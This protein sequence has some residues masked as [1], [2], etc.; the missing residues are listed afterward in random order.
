MGG[1]R[2]KSNT[3][4]TPTPKKRDNNSIDDDEPTCKSLFDEMLK[5]IT[6]LENNVLILESS[7]AVSNQA[8]T[9]LSGEVDRLNSEVDRLEQY[10]RRSC[11]VISGIH[12]D[13]N[14]TTQD[15]YN[16]IKNLTTNH[17]QQESVSPNTFDF[18]FDKCHRIGPVKD[19][20]QSV[21]VKFR[22]DAFRE[23]LYKNRKCLPKGVK[24]RVSLTKKRIDILEKANEKIKELNG[25]KFAYAD[26]NGNLKLLLKEKTDK[27]RWTLQFDNLE[28]LD[29]LLDHPIDGPD[30]HQNQDVPSQT[31]EEKNDE[32]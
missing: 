28:E 32:F 17:L 27:G 12:P 20:K 22:S 31:T 2:K 4:S 25:V 1:S 3:P 13:K 9:L 7:L 15:L 10:S 29:G 21:I 11:L 16:K 23:H 14:E 26:A 8:N 5:R 6:A 19:N 24:F 30:E 18:E